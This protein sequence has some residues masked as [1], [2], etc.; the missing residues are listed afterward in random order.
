M[1]QHF[2]VMAV[3]LLF[4][5][6]FLVAIF[7]RISPVIRDG[8]AILIATISLVLIYALIKPVMIDGQI[9]SYWMGNWEPVEGYAI[10]I[11]YEVDALGLFF[12][13]L[14]VT[15]FWLSGIYSLGYLKK[16]ANKMHYYTLYLMLSASVLGLVLT[17]D[18]F[19]M[20]IMIE[21]MTFAS[22]AL[23]AFRNKEAIAL[24]AGFKYLVLGSIGSSMT[25]A[26]VA[27]MYRVCHTLNMAQI[28]SIIG[29]KFNLTTI[30]AFGL[31]VAG[32]GVKSY[33]VPFHTPAADAYTA[34]PTSISMIFSGMV[35]KA[36]V[37]G[38]IRMVYV[39]FRAMD[40]SSIQ[41]LL[42]VFGA[43]TMF[44]GVTMAL[45]QHD[46]KRLLAFHSI[47]QIGYVITAI[48]LGTALGLNAG[49]FHAMN[50]TLF[51]GLLFLTAGAVLTATGTTNL[52]KLGGLSKRMPVT[53]VCFLVGAF[54]ISGL[55]PF[56]GFA[57]KW[58][59][60][61]AIY[62]K[63]VESGN[64]LF[65]I[66]TITALIVSVMTLASFI[67]V[68]QAVFFGQ[69]NPENANAKE[70]P[71]I[72]QIP[73]VIMAVLCVLT[74]LFYNVVEKFL[75]APAAGAALGVSNYIDKMMGAGYAKAAGITDIEAAPA[76]F[77]F[78]NPLV[79]L[80]LFVV[81]FLGVYIVMATSKSTRGRML[82]G[83]EGYDP[84]YATFFSGEQEEF[85]QVGGSD[86]FWG[87]KTDWKGYYKVLQGLHSGIVTD[88]A[89]YIVMG[90]AIIILV[91]FIC[92][93]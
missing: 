93:R 50:H 22:V 19:N 44:I 81:V 28:S 67:K 77:S 65:A 40:R 58:M 5:G 53:T 3:M 11:G 78:W 8:I 60:Y 25:L 17:G 48:G 30:M 54:S 9:I 71:V 47:S 46:F 85:S 76:A 80:L 23:T 42:V 63:A 29:G 12:A 75:L 73:M 1:I 88:Y 6:A 2:P 51:K 66:A 38:I 13:L 70:V 10:G 18:L 52:D 72:M 49:L 27:L 37:Y 26:G 41:I 31:I 43:V 14:V 62:T 4:L 20:F 16:D 36:G 55:P 64:I 86:L 87:F 21:I 68:T 56:N 74:G 59:V 34:A 82:E 15:T 89:S 83:G 7:G 69:E 79:W 92:L 90:A 61:Q 32:L 91:M 39:V 24:E 45:A 84:K 33:I 35:N 57:S